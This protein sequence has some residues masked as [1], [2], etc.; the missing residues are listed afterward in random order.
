M[1]LDPSAQDLRDAVRGFIRG[2]GVLSATTTPCGQPLPP[3][4]AHALSVLLDAKREGKRPSQSELCAS[5]GIDKSNVARLCRRMEARGHLVQQ[6][7]TTDARVRR[8]ALTPKGER[9]AR[10]VDA[11]GERRVAALL[12]ALPK[13][14]QGPV[15]E[16]LVELTRAVHE[17][18]ATEETA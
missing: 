3:S 5:L 11:A 9:L 17:S 12:E 8:L 13:A 10:E 16:A 14:R 7:C 4:H 6:V 1:R 18:A 2:F 15:I